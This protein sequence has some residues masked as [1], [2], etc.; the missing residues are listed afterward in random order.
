MQLQ[1][2][3]QQWQNIRNQQKATIDWRFSVEQARQKLARAYPTRCIT[4]QF[5]TAV[6]FWAGSS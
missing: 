6:F 3:V 2:E 5:S 4:I 1:R